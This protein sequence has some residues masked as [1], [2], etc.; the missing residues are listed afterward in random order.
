[1]GGLAVAFIIFAGI[2]ST[3]TRPNDGTVWLLGRPDLEVL[4]VVER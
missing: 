1:M 4:A 3:K 2:D